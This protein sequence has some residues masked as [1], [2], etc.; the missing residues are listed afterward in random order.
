MNDAL[1]GGTRQIESIVAIDPLSSRLP[2]ELPEAE[3]GF[4]HLHAL[5]GGLMFAD[6]LTRAKA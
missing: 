6:E 1:Q 3:E 5:F 4:P 2:A